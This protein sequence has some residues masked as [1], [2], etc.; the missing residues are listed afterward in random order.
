M[1]FFKG[2]ACSLWKNFDVSAVS[3]Y[4]GIVMVTVSWHAGWVETRL[5]GQ[6]SSFLFSFFL[7]S[8]LLAVMLLQFPS[9]YNTVFSDCHQNREILASHLTSKGVYWF[10]N[11]NKSTPDNDKISLYHVR[12]HQRSI[13]TI[14]TY[15][16]D[17]RLSKNPKPTITNLILLAVKL[18][19]TVSFTAFVS[20]ANA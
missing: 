5:F 6:N 11:L 17:S 19:T 13:P 16:C 9:I 18:Q 1:T 7:F 20:T 12:S 15:I 10:K 8:F 3:L 2:R 4:F 14:N